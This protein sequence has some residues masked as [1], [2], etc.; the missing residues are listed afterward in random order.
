LDELAVD[1]D[2]HALVRALV[3]ELTRSGV[4]H[5][6]ACPGARSTP[7]VVSLRRHAGVRLWM[8]LD[9]RSAAFFALGMAKASGR[10][11]ALL[12]TSGTAAVNF[13][14]AVVEAW[15]ARVPLVV[16][17]ADRPPELRDIGAL[18]TIDQV[19]L[20]GSH[21]KWFVDMSLPET[22]ADSVR[23]ARAVACRAV[24]V[25][26]ADGAP[27][28][29][30][31]NV[32]LREPLL[33]PAAAIDDVPS[34]AAPP[35]AIETLPVVSRPAG[36]ELASLAHALRATRRGLIVCGPQDDRRLA[37][38]VAALA[39]VLRFPILADALSGARCGPHHSSLIVDS[40]D[41][42]LRDD[43][44]ATELR[45]ELILRFGAT[46]VSKPLLAYLERHRACRH[47]LADP[48]LPRRW[49]DPTLTVTD[50]LAVDPTALCA[51]LLE[52][53]R[54]AERPAAT[55]PV[56]ALSEWLARWMEAQRRA[57]AALTERLDAEP[58]L[59]EPA[60]FGEL[61]ALIPEGT[62][63]FA[64]NSMPIR[65]LDTFFPGGPRAVHFLANRG[66]SGIDGTVSTALGAC[67]A[68]RQPLVLVLGDLSFYHDMNGL[69]AARRHGLTAV[70]VLLNND[71]GGIFS[72]LPHADDPEH[73]EELFGTPHGLEF[74][75]AAELY[76]LRYRA[77][78]DRAQFRAAVTEA[79]GA[80]EVTVVE[81]RTRRDRNAELHRR[82]W[83]CGAGTL[84]GNDPEA[85]RP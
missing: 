82:L 65:D 75:P 52:T 80:P 15:H 1:D 22:G 69:L 37:A 81:V 17:T 14:P 26:T 61:A 24:A 78:A 76:G 38:A 28:P 60:V 67:A 27:G 79:L 77:A 66:A 3:D 25:A 48:G 16:L 71:G 56:R 62:T 18:Q 55:P 8:H 20:Y 58:G 63:V 6:C 85:S 41:V 29:V 34:R 42:F 53:L 59:S 84:G 5:A 23:Y 10:P 2:R 19:R 32:P 9:E 51:D 12:S 46:P 47:V 33:P 43:T 72:L 64:G 30:H 45:P 21:V 73:F 54:S 68:G 49:P 13:A 31:L 36:T 40:Y 50:A 35:P 11:V 44:T 70:I 83:R 39:D 4:A 7:L 57:R 74:R